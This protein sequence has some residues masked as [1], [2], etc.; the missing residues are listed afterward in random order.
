MKMHLAV[1]LATAA[2]VWSACSGGGLSYPEGSAVTPG[3]PRPQTVAPMGLVG[4]LQPQGGG[5]AAGSVSIRMITGSTGGS[6]PRVDLTL[7][8]APPARQLPWHIHSGSCGSNGPIVGQAGAYALISTDNQG[9]GRLTI[10][11]P[12][13]LPQGIPLYVNVHAANG[14]SVIACAPLT[15]GRMGG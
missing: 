9:Q 5:T 10:G 2:V 13:G 14:E 7:T 11:L 6:S 8:G 4:T 12:F 15:S 3:T 1:P